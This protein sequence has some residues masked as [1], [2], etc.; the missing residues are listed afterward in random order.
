MRAVSLPGG[1]MKPFI[2]S[3]AIALACQLSMASLAVAQTVPQ[4]TGPAKPWSLRGGI[5]LLADPDAFL[6]NFEIE[7]FMR[8]EVAVGVALQ[9]GVDDDYTVVSPMVFARYVAFLTESSNDVVKKLQPYLQGGVGLTHI[10]LDGRGRD[11]DGTDFL[12][13][14]GFGLDYYPLSEPFSVGSR[15]LVNIIPGRVVGER[16]YLSWEILSLR[17]HW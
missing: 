6:M 12:L 9:L 8:D 2:R 15:F 13:S 14:L 10:D 16:I 4:Q 17:Y 3:L 7:R 11:T 1:S 5:G